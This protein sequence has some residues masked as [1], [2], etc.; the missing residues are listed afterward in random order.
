MA[1]RVTQR[2]IAAAA[3]VSQATVSL[4]LNG[5][6]DALARETRDRVLAVIK[7]TGYVPNPAARQLQGGRNRILGVFTY[8]AVFPSSDA[9]FYNPFFV[10][11]EEAAQ[12]RGLDLLLFTSATAANGQRRIFGD[13]NRL[14]LADGCILLGRSIDRAELARL[15]SESY[16]FVTIGRRNDAAGPVPYVGAGYAVATVDLVRRARELGHRAFAYVGPGDGAE[17][18]EDRLRGYREGTDG[19]GK[20]THVP[21]AEE[22]GALVQRLVGVGVTA[23]VV[24]EAADAV[25]LVAAAR[26]LGIDVPV[27]LSVLALGDPTRA[28]SGDAE[29]TGFRIPRGQMGRTSVDVLAT[30]L[31]HGRDEIP[32]LLLP[33]EYVEGGTLAV[34]PGSGKPGRRAPG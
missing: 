1:P 19:V 27:D 34:P 10:G 18:S 20:A 4:V 30:L 2:D 14:R 13:E 22:P 31:E 6:G 17:G 9:D 3:K 28:V 32:Q 25:A 12:A 26:S 33:C 15:N 11:I 21:T 24:E 7:Q 23:L 16:P 5:R 29:L 8:E